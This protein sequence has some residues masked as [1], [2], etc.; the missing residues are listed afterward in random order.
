MAAYGGR[1]GWIRVGWTLVVGAGLAAAAGGALRAQTFRSAVD[2]AS[3]G[4]T[5]VDKKGGLVTDLSAADFEVAED[6][7][8]QTVTLFSR[9]SRAGGG[10][11]GGD[12][13]LHLGLLFDA[14]GS[15]E[16]DIKFSRSAV[17]KFLNALTETV[18]ITLVDFDT[19]VRVARYGPNDYPRL[20]ERIRRRK[21]DGWTALFD[22]TG[23]YLDGAA[24]QEGRRILVIY[25][26]GDDNSS[27]LTY[28]GLLDL[29]KASDVTVYVVGFLEHQSRSIQPD[30]R[31]KL[32][33]IAEVTGGQAFFPLS[34]KDLEPTYEK[35]LAEIKAQ[36][37]LGYLSTNAKADGTWRK[38]QVK[39]SRPGVKIRTRRGYFAPYRKSP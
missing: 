39:V 1:V 5:A 32:R 35:V 31:I 28:T 15:M 11:T 38:V 33:E 13:E 27:S 20:I 21:I 7:K 24:M 22:A 10:Q 9:G 26:D 8:P 25:T 3:F 37:T 36:Y 19:E 34:M 2:L 17:V 14:S 4:V 30:L 18:D 29:L 16:E 6:G 12:P 23:V